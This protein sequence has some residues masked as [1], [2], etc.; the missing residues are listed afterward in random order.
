MP[1]LTPQF[2]MDLESQ[3][4][5]IAEQEY[6]RLTANLWWQTITRT[7]TTGAR[8]DILTWLLSTA[9]IK[10]EGKGGNIAFDDLV[11][12]YTEIEMNWSGNGLKLRRDTFE[13]TDG[14]G[15][16]F[17]S[18]WTSDTSAYM[19]YWPQERAA[20]FL[21]NGHDA[22][23]YTGYDKLAFFATNH[24]PNPYKPGT[25]LFANLFTG[26]ASGSYP[27]G[28]PIDD[29]VSPDRALQSLSQIYSYVATIKMPNGV[30]PR[31][32]RPK[33]IICPPRLF[34][35]A[36]QLTNAKFLAQNAMGGGAAS[37]DVE[38]LI[39]SLG[40]A[41]PVQ[42][43]ELAG[44]ENDTT[45]FVACEQLSTM[46][47]GAAIFTVRE[48]YRINY[49]GVVDDAVLNRADELEWHNKGRNKYSPGHPFLLFKCKAA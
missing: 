6:T 29:S 5:V 8:R 20:D 44:F 14:N 34:P 41:T 25:A 24:P 23:K 1:A 42:A 15:M 11:A 31:F 33:W 43:D 49:Y 47:L 27:G 38:A 48:P 12:T 22:T 10:D 32:L 17:A 4:Q 45:Y 37:A 18:Q 28:V 13:D 46:Q 3:M 39:K 36:V 35:R 19:A 21:K 26:T 30:T 9:Q 7:R 40:Y 16:N 2:L